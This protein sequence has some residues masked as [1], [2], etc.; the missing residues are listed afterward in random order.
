MLFEI[1]HNDYLL[2]LFPI[3]RVAGHDFTARIEL[4]PLF[5]RPPYRQ[6]CKGGVRHLV[7]LGHQT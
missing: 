3:K 5:Y 4:P 6:A 7:N 1:I 2:T